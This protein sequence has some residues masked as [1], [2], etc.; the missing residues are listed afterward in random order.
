[1]QAILI[2]DNPAARRSLANLIQEYCPHIQLLGEAATVAEG[3]QLIIE[4][5]PQLVFLDIEMPDGNGF[6]LLKKLPEINFQVIFISSH[7][8][9]ALRA[10]KHSALDYILKP[11]D[12]DELIEAIK[13]AKSEVLNHKTL[14]KI[15]TLIVNTTD[16]QK[17]PTKLVLKDK[18]GIQIVSICDVVY[19]EANGSYTHF[20][21][22]DQ[23]SLLV[24]KGLK[25]Y[26]SI[27][28]NEQFFR[29]H[30]SYLI[31][32]DYLLRY[33]GRDG[34]FLLMKDGSK[35]PL[36]TRKKNAFLKIINS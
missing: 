18:Y 17:A 14:E 36:A 13:K 7:E 34:G 25:E 31:N 15:Q 1:M 16:H 19:L 24:S 6:D 5:K 22:H 30:Q 12:P 10:I 23:E 28:S 4:Q 21:I 11:I 3:I 35:I 9:Y 20:H 32:L 33:D 2:D 29:C 26:E 8:K 27:V